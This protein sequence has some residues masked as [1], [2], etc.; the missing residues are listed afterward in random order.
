MVQGM[1]DIIVGNNQESAKAFN[2]YIEALFPYMSKT[3][4]ESDTKML[5]VMEQEVKKG[6]LFFSPV[7]MNATRNVLDKV[8]E[9]DLVRIGKFK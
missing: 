5:E 3:K 9:P 8:N 7:L 1:T 6:P 2:S 4:K